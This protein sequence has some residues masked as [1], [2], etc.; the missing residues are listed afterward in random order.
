MKKIL[1]I[2]IGLF[3]LGGTGADIL[4]QNRWQMYLAY[5]DATAVAASDRL[6]Y[7][8]YNGNLLSYDWQDG[9]VSFYEK[10][11]GL[12]DKGIRFMDYS[13]E[14]HCLVLVYDN[15]NVDFLY[16]NGTVVNIP[17][18][19]NFADIE[20][21]PTALTVNGEW[22]A[23]ST[24]E[25]VIVLNIPAAEV[26]GYYKLGH[27]VKKAAVVDDGV[28]AVI[29][30]KLYYGSLRDNIYD[31]ALWTKLSDV[32]TS[33]IVPMPQGLYQ[34][35]A[36]VPS[37]E[38]SA[39]GAYYIR[40]VPGKKTKEQTKVTNIWVVMGCHANGQV[41]LT[42]PHHVVCIDASEPEKVKATV[43]NAGDF[44]SMTVDAEGSFWMTDRENNLHC[45]TLDVQENGLQEHEVTIGQYGPR[46]DLCYK[47][48]Y[49]GD[50]LWVAGGRMDY[51][52][53]KEFLPTAMSY[54]DGKWNFLP[55]KGISLA[56][57]GRYRN[58]LSVVQSPS[59]PSD[60][61]VGCM[62]GLLHFK[63]NELVEQY[64]HKNSPLRV[65]D[66]LGDNPNYVIVDGLCFDPKGNLWMTNY[67]SPLSIHV[68]KTDG[69][70]K[71]FGNTQFTRIVTPETMLI[72]KNGLIWVNSK[73]TTEK[74]NSGLYALDINGTI[75][76][77]SD[78]RS[79]FRSSAL[80]QD[81]TNCSFYELNTICEDL[82]GQIWMGCRNGVYAVTRPDTWFSYD[83]FKI[84]QPKVPRNDGTNLADYL[85]TG[86]NISAIA[87][88]AGNRKWI[89]TLGAGIFVVSPDGTEVVEHISTENSP[90]LSDNIFSLAFNLHTGEL[91]IGTDMGLCSYQ[92]HVSSPV[93]SMS[94]NTVRVYPNPVRPDYHGKVVIEGLTDGAEVKIVTSGSQLVAR[95]NAVGGSYEW[96]V[97]HMTSGRRV[98]SGVYYVLAASVAGKGQTISKIVVI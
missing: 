45:Y 33:N 69:S 16:D 7:G 95:G 20:I 35:V 67:E 24:R 71:S 28:Y 40:S 29:D 46:R 88:D 83:G 86:I 14:N 78:D 84:Y 82:N 73:R 63:E 57:K 43:R 19:K 54:E 34:L 50:R 18:I 17:Q 98:A 39:L 3:L 49:S 30:Q 97:C 92:T 94:K 65:A 1:Y 51:A 62:N 10:S 4:A 38:S 13:E 15:N 90:I 9:N 96:D 81:G 77:E 8:L 91:M 55:D 66:G 60:V 74:G 11:E 25:G 85:L 80:N 70:W 42:S 53:G 36:S 21:V 59:S 37:L 47:L 75:D 5:Q 26:K 76:D 2:L 48:H 79:L 41:V 31:F 87:V 27:E 23:I 6:L 68:L 44:G 12:S 72:G 52:G 61:Y 32:P 93:T 89:G 56:E 58:V 22:A 64:Y